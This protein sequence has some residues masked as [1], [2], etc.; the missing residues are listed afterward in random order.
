M[1]IV[2]WIKGARVDYLRSASNARLVGAQLARLLQLVVS[3]SGGGSSTA[4]SFHVIGAS[5]GSHVAGSAG[6]FLKRFDI[7]LGRISGNLR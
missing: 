3:L 6:R 4:D 5:L 2:D 1:I 7:T